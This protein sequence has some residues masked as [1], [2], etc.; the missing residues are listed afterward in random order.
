M[1]N[2]KI[3]CAF[4]P[5]F[6]RYILILADAS[7]VGMQAVGKLGIPPKAYARKDWWRKEGSV[8][9]VGSAPTRKVWGRLSLALT[10]THVTGGGAL[11]L[12]LRFA[13]RV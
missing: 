8:G 12:I 13:K 2:M 11:L 6:V 5:I 1:F 10:V 7:L 4:S 9:D 3:S